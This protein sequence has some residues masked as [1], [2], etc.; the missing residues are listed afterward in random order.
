MTEI[1]CK[2]Q[3]DEEQTPAHDAHN[4]LLRQMVVGK[5]CLDGEKRKP[6]V[7][8]DIGEVLTYGVA[9]LPF[10]ELGTLSAE[11]FEED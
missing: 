7:K 5:E 2:V 4:G 10:L 11:M 8:L 9:S 3:W 6:I 1:P